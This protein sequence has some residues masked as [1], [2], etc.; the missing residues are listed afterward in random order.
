MERKTVAI[1]RMVY[2]KW[3]CTHP[4]DNPNENYA[5]FQ[6]IL[7]EI[8]VYVFHLFSIHG[9]KR[10]RNSASCFQIECCCRS[11][12]LFLIWNIVRFAAAYTQIHQATWLCFSFVSI[13]VCV[14]IPYRIVLYKS[15]RSICSNF[16]V[17][18]SV[19]C[20]IVSWHVFTLLCFVFQT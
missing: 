6:T 8:R 5:Y 9:H 7:W 3:I 19:V 12:I 4:S 16:Q 17:S 18:S 13:V 14:R 2:I 15:H 1:G 20:A 11:C 10:N